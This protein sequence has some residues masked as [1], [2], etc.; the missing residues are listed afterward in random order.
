MS[1][2]DRY[3]ILSNDHDVED[4]DV[5]TRIVFDDLDAEVFD[6]VDIEENFSAP[7]AADIRIDEAP[8]SGF[9]APST[10]SAYEETADETR[11]AEEIRNSP[12]KVYW[13]MSLITAMV[14]FSGLGW[15][16]WETRSD[17]ILTS[18]SIIEKMWPKDRRSAA[19][20]LLKM[21]PFIVPFTSKEKT[22]GV[23]NLEIEVKTNAQFEFL[24][25]IGRAREVIFTFLRESAVT[26]RREQSQ[27][28]VERIN[29][30][31]GNKAVV[32][33]H[34]IRGQDK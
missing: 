26:L 16:W 8:A 12:R 15:L 30:V 34:A 32:S 1:D 6:S 31:M 11:G 23:V 22:I 14:L 17:G 20:V 28:L 5:I 10:E 4:K 18:G 9:R 13:L 25:Q 29:K 3:K 19:T 27:T 2:L 24:S 33:I 21:E 7:P